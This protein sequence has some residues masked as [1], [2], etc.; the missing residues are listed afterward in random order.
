VKI[1]ADTTPSDFAKLSNFP[2]EVLIRCFLSMDGLSLLNSGAVCKKW[3]TVLNSDDEMT[4]EVWKTSIEKTYP[5]ANLIEVATQLKKFIKFPN[6]EIPQEKISQPVDEISAS[7]KMGEKITKKKR[8]RRKNPKLKMS[9]KARGKMFIYFFGIL[10]LVPFV[11][12][13]ELIISR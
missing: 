3:Y 10:G 11:P 12:I 13:S 1:T 9:K 4:G 7:E 8:N 5:K 6:Q 2:A